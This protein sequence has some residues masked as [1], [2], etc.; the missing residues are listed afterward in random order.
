[1]SRWCAGVVEARARAFLSVGSNIRPEESVTV[2][3]ELLAGN[4]DISL[5]GISTFYRTPPI[6]F[7][8][9]ASRGETESA[10][11][12]EAPDFLNGVLEIRT[13]LSQEGLQEV[14]NEVEVALGRERTGDR[15][16]PRAMDLDLLLYAPGSRDNGVDAWAALA[17][18]APV[19][20]PDVR[21]R[22]FVALPLFELAPDLELPPDGA[23]I[24]IVAESFSGPCGTPEPALTRML[25]SRF[26]PPLPG[27]G[28]P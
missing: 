5:T 16:A 19:I 20:H 17:P 26:L 2:A 21:G 8:G 23:P 3:L 27:L 15:Y 9:G 7:P 25:R 12:Y 24:R 28:T 1:M 6:P 18:D 4:P 10:Q 11:G 14:L 13:G 22:S